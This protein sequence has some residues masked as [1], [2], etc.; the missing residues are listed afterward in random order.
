MMFQGYSVKFCL[1]VYYSVKSTESWLVD[2]ENK[3]KATLHIVM[4]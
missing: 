2:L 3:E 1:A 4:P